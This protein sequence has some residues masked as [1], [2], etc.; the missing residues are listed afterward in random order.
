MPSRAGPHY[1]SNMKVPVVQGRDF[2]ERDRDGAPCVAV[3]N[4]AFVQKYFADRAALGKHLT[5]FAATDEGQVRKEPCE[6][7]G[8]VR[9][10]A[11]QSFQKDLRPFF[12]FAVLQSNRKRTTMLVST[13]G[14]PGSL[15][16]PVRNTIR[17]LDPRIP[18]TD[19]QTLGEYFAVGLYPFRILAVLMGACG[20]MALLLA[21]L[22]IY[23]IISYS[24]A[25]RTRE[26][27][28]RIALGALQK[29]ILKMVI[30]QGMVLVITGLGLGLLLSIALTRVLTSSL[31]EL[32]LPFPVSATDPLTFASVTMLLALIALIACLIPARRATEID[33][34]EA[35]RYE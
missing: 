3:I 4:E 20:V 2:D 8:V 5:K 29:D 13:T 33:P 18:L 28:I 7:V 11:W 27:G 23:G 25:Q 22:G 35:L 34:I 17:E 15:L 21:S 31:L 30:W 32:E 9:D 24:V 12:T 19:V 26:L 1:F 14:D 6:I 10:D 16:T